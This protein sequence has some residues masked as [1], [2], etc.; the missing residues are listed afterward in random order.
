MLAGRAQVKPSSVNGGLGLSGYRLP[1]YILGKV[2]YPKYCVLFLIRPTTRMIT[3]IASDN[4]LNQIHDI[5]VFQT[6]S[7]KNPGFEYL[8]NENLLS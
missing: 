7:V 1:N 2:I 4:E 3:N 6:L 8:S 5:D